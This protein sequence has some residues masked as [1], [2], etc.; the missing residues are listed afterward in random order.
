MIKVS[1]ETKWEGA[2]IKVQGQKVVSRTAFELGLIVQGQAELLCAV[3]YG[4][5]AASIITQSVEDGTELRSPVLNASKDHDPGHNV[6]TFKKIDKPVD[7][8]E[9]L[10][11]TAVDYAPYVEFGTVRSDAQ[12]FLRPA[13]DMAKGR[14]LT[15]LKKNGRF[16]FGEY[17][18]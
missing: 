10:V 13:L 1:I 5:L 12:P 7:K 8:N 14:I 4:Y 9:V 18:K 6:D 3:D 16:Y 2:P 11:G 17:L 15:I